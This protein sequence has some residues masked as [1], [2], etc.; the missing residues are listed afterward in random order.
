MPLHYYFLLL[1]T[2]F[3][4]GLS[5][6]LFKKLNQRFLK[7][8]LSFSGAYLF[9]LC[10]LHLIPE[11]Y[12]SSVKWIGAYVLVG[13]FLQI[14]LEVFSEGIEHGHIHVHAHHEHAFPL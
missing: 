11:V 12:A 10:V 1:I 5:I 4:S 3:L 6:F 8:L 2:V 9:A 7:M 13:F 14:L